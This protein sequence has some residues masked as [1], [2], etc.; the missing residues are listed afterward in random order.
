MATIR[1][2]PDFKEFLQLLK[3][4]EVEYLLVGGYEV[5][6]PPLRLDSFRPAPRPVV[7]AAFLVGYGCN[8]EAVFELHKEDRERKASENHLPG[9]FV[10]VQGAGPRLLPRSGTRGQ[11]F[12]VVLRSRRWLCGF[13]SLL[14][15]GR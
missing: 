10:V 8:P 5:G 11:D 9:P 7:G 2:P 6:R 15:C 1:L 3:A 4:N 12:L 14:P 13:L